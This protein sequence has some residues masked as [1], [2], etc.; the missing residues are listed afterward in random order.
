M[1]N[2][3]PLSVCYFKVTPAQCLGWGFRD[4][5]VSNCTI[6]DVM[7]RTKPQLPERKF[8]FKQC[9]VLLVDVICILC[10]G[11]TV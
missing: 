3:P 1:S 6:S 7:V 11:L 10:V 5:P 9:F 8:I 2:V 4:S